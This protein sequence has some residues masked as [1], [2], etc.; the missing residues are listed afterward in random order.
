MTD[1]FRSRLAAKFAE[2]QVRW[3]LV[4]QTNKEKTRGLAAPYIDVQTVMDRLDDAIGPE[5][6]R[7]AYQQLG[8]T[9]ICTL[10]IRIDGEWIAKCDGA[11]PTDI[12]P[13]KGQLSDSLK[14]AAVRWG[15]GRYLHRVPAMWADLDD[16]GRLK[17]EPQLPEW[18][19]PQPEQPP[20]APDPATDQS[21][22]L[23]ADQKAAFL[24]RLAEIRLEYGEVYD[25]ALAKMTPKDPA[26]IVLASLAKGYLV[27]LRKTCEAIK[28]GRAQRQPGE[29]D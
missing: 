9:T 21:K 18:A 20:P 25:Q 4:G 24:N 12:E 8:T 13:E 16:R 22:V 23:N 14:R 7:D 29:D 17:T 2:D 1:T 15:I 6:W 3:R 27:M 19:L 10:S 26:T 5:N 28:A 11:G